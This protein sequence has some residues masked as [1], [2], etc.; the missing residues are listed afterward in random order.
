MPWNT[1]RTATAGSPALSDYWNTDARDNLNTLHATVERFS[2]NVSGTAL[3]AGD[4]VIWSGTA[5]NQITTVG[6]SAGY[7][8]TDIGVLTDTSV[9]AGGTAWARLGGYVAALKVTGAVARGD[10]LQH[11]GTAT[12]AQ[13]GTAGAFARALSAN[14]SGT[15]FVEAR[16]FGNQQV[17][18]SMSF[19]APALTLGTANAAGAATTAVRTDATI[20]AFGTAL[21]GGMTVGGAGTAGTAALTARIDHQHPLTALG[22]SSL[23]IIP[24]ARAKHDADQSVNHDTVTTIAL[25]TE[26]FDTDGMH[27]NVTNNSRLTAQTAGMYLIGGAIAW[28]TASATGWRQA[29]ITMGTAN[30]LLTFSNEDGS[31]S[32]NVTNVVLTTQALQVGEFVELAAYQNSGGAMNV[33]SV[34]PY[35]PVLWMVRLGRTS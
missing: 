18:A 14:A 23:P 15:A 30:T 17:A 6:G 25:N 9:A 1:I 26:V 32:Y 3:A 2:A 12:Y 29:R 33:L 13:A 28:N 8:A 22:Q 10:L 31:T 4:V 35:T 24:F 27:D 20:L 34:D 11:S 7:T 16:L 21:P 5:N 19:A